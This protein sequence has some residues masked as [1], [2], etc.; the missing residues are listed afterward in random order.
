MNYFD[1]APQ[2]G[3]IRELENTLFWERP[4]APSPLA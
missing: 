2:L 3:V 4:A 1:H